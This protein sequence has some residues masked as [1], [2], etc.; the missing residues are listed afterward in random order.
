VR[1][2]LEHA[3]VS[4]L[5]ILHVIGG[6]KDLQRRAKSLGVASNR[7]IFAGDEFDAASV[8]T[9]CYDA[10]PKGLS[11]IPLAHLQSVRF[12]R[13]SRLLK[14]LKLPVF[15]SDIDLVLQRGVK[16]LLQ[17]FAAHDVVLN[18]NG[19]S[20]NAG[21]RFTANLLLLNPTSNAALF[22]RFLRAYLDTALGKDEVTR[23]IDQFGLMQARHHLA[24]HAPQ[25]RIGF[26]DTDSDI[27]N[28]MYPAYQEHPFRFLSLY[29][30]FDMSTLPDTG[31]APIAKTDRTK[32][33][34][35]S[36]KRLAAAGR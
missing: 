16:D 19:R 11:A 7:L 30:G 1:S 17:K 13:L 5:V 12:L 23:W 33:T 8:T 21:S 2:I 14:G 31:K 22:L 6:A 32:K 18:E 26:F 28:V 34:M 4:S 25:S 9:R 15:V 24:L 27:N 35:G 3:D 29:H 20:E 10:P 36:R